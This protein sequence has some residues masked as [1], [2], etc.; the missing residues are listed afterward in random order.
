MCCGDK[1][2]KNRTNNKAMC[3]FFYREMLK[4]MFVSGNRRRLFKG[5]GCAIDK[6]TEKALAALRQQVLKIRCAS[7]AN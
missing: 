2:T 1:V 4:R 7:L 3:L 5:A 6:H